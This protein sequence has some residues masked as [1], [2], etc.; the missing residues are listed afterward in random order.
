MN[1]SMKYRNTRIALTLLLSVA[2]YAAAA[3]SVTTD[4]SEVD[5]IGPILEN[6]L[7]SELPLSLSSSFET[8]GEFRFITP[9]SPN[10]HDPSADF[11]ADML[12]YLTVTICKVVDDSECTLVKTFTS[13]TS[14][15]RIR[16]ENKLGKFFIVNWTTGAGFDNTPIYRISVDVPSE[17]LGT[18]D[19]PPSA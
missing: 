9:I 16:I 18:V 5:L 2:I 13:T 17:T 7:N 6:H 10:P 11:D 1:T 19:L 8:A 15:D 4:A 3:P 14:T 12:P